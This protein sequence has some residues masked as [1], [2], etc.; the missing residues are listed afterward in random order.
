M[1]I[2]KHV[3]NVKEA[4]AGI[5]SLAIFVPELAFESIKAAIKDADCTLGM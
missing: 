3:A 2:K 5:V 1:N 4:A